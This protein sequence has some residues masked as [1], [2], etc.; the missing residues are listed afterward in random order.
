[1]K[2]TIPSIKVEDRTIG[3]MHSAL[4]SYNKK[5]WVKISFQEYRRLCYEV[6][7]QVILQDI[8]LPVDVLQ[9]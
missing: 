1:M 4:A 9:S 5:N 7:S 8:D 6:C 2:K 3:N